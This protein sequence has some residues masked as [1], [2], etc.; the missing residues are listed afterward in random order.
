MDNNAAASSTDRCSIVG[1]G[2]PLYLQNGYTYDSHI[3]RYFCSSMSCKNLRKSIYLCRLCDKYST[4]SS[5]PRAHCQSK[6]HVNNVQKQCDMDSTDDYYNNDDD[7]ATSESNLASNPSTDDLIDSDNGSIMSQSSNEENAAPMQMLDKSLVTEDLVYFSNRPTMIENEA[8]DPNTYDHDTIDDTCSVVDNNDPPD[9][10]LRDCHDNGYTEKTFLDSISNA[11]NPITVG[12]EGD[13]QKYDILKRCFSNGLHIEQH[14]YY[15]AVMDAEAG[16]HVVCSAFASG[17]TKKYCH[18]SIDNQDSLHHL[19]LAKLSSDLTPAQNEIVVALLAHSAFRGQDLCTPKSIN[20]LFRIY[21]KGKFAIHKTLPGPKPM[22]M[23]NSEFSYLSHEEIIKHMFLTSRAPHPFSSFDNVVHGNSKRGKALLSSVTNDVLYDAEGFPFFHVKTMLWTDAFNPLNTKDASLH[24]CVATIGALDGDHSGKRGYSI[25]LGPAKEDTDAV[26]RRLVRELN[27]LSAGE[28]SEGLPF[29][30]YH[31]HLNKIVHVVVHPFVVLCDQPDTA[32]RTKTSSGGRFHLK[33]GTS[34]DFFAV[35]K[36]VTCCD[37][38]YK[39][40]LAPSF[41]QFEQLQTCGRCYSFDTKRMKY[42]LPESYPTAQLHHEDVDNPTTSNELK[43]KV[44]SVRTKHLIQACIY[45]FDRLATTTEPEDGHAWS[46]TTADVY[47]QT[48]CINGRFRAS[49]IKNAKNLNKYNLMLQHESS[50]GP[51]RERME[52]HKTEHPEQ[53]RMPSFPAFW[54]LRDADIHTFPTAIAH[55]I[56]LGNVK[57]VTEVLLLENYVCLSGKEK[58]FLSIL[59]KKLQLLGSFKLS[60]MITPNKAGKGDCDFTFKGLQ[61]KEWLSIARVS[62]WLFGHALFCDPEDLDFTYS[63]KGQKQGMG[64]FSNSDQEKWCRRR[65]ISVQTMPK[66]NRKTNSVAQH[67]WFDDLIHSP[68]KLFGHFDDSDILDVTREW[69]ADFFQ[70]ELEGLSDADEIRSLFYD[71]VASKQSQPNE[72]DRVYPPDR[73]F[74][75]LDTIEDNDISEIISLHL[76]LISRL[77]GVEAQDRVTEIKKLVMMFLTKVHRFDL[78]CTPTKDGNASNKPSLFSKPNLL[79]LLNLPDDIERYGHMRLL[80]VRFYMFATLSFAIYMFPV[81]VSSFISLFTKIPHL[82]YSDCFISAMHQE[83]GGMGEGFIPRIKSV[84]HQLKHNF[85]YHAINKFVADMA[86][87]DLAEDLITHISPDPTSD[88]I[89]SAELLRRAALDHMVIKADNPPNTFFHTPTSN[90][91]GK[92]NPAELLFG[93]DGSFADGQDNSVYRFDYAVFDTV[94]FHKCEVV[95][96]VV[97]RPTGRIFA[98]AGDRGH[99]KKIGKQHQ[100]YEITFNLDGSAG[101][102]LNHMDAFYFKLK[103]I[104][105]VGIPVGTGI[106]PNLSSSS[107]DGDLTVL[108]RKDMVCGLIMQHNNPKDHYYVTTLDWKE[109][110]LDQ[111]NITDSVGFY[112]PSTHEILNASRA[113]QNIS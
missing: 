31:R 76:C 18:T 15:T 41:T 52:Q 78:K 57:F 65:G 25:W 8:T 70:N 40:L 47:L 32:S 63:A 99:M 16:Q 39:K 2:C 98:M 55:E 62:K 61:C 106:L 4:H 110:C 97:H 33:F 21:S 36:N 23:P 104:S 50:T 79:S 44:R 38:C 1:C 74:Y 77:M 12:P 37:T 90:G 107:S 89:S 11:H 93:F 84:I 60:Y 58:S 112:Y 28:T 19:L 66:T 14:N 85:S 34:M 91:N 13:A 6:R 72:S 30:C 108:Y 71:Y 80:W 68:E 75:A 73:Y 101:T 3:G 51:Q 96:C 113:D 105:G 102:V 49:L 48:F 20:D 43:L 26:E 111:D 64:G 46:G 59:E 81:V 5:F 7:D 53:Y 54:C 100:L 109:L 9:Q 29:Y 35:E 56:F 92:S 24:L 83:L 95:P 27:H 17:N 67:I 45:A 69:H 87:S 88:T 86:Y 10:T 22:K 103:E 94:K 42:A 82:Y